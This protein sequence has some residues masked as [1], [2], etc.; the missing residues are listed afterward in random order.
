MPPTGLHGEHHLAPLLKRDPQRA[1]QC[2]S[3]SKY[4]QIV[5]DVLLEA[6]AH[7]GGNGSTEVDNVADLVEDGARAAHSP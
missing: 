4:R 6:S 3:V 5:C 1:S 7:T 2:Q